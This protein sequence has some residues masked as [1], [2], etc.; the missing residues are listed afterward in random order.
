MSN[1]YE[2][3]PAE[4]TRQLAPPYNGGVPVP[5]GFTGQDVMIHPVHAINLFFLTIS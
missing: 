3:G 1:A 5:M 4:S 2:M